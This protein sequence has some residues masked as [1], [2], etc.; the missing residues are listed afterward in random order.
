[1]RFSVCDFGHTLFYFQK[2]LQEK[3]VYDIVIVLHNL[4][5]KVSSR[6]NTLVKGVFSIYSCRDGRDCVATMR[7]YTFSVRSSWDALFYGG[8]KRR[9]PST[10]RNKKTERLEEPKMYH[11]IMDHFMRRI[12]NRLKFSD[13]FDYIIDECFGN[14]ITDMQEYLE[15]EYLEY[16]ALVKKR[17]ELEKIV[18][19]EE[20]EKH[21]QYRK[22]DAEMH[23]LLNKTLF[24]MGIKAGIKLAK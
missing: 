19:Q 3:K 17:A 9:R 2:C 14:I 18:F 13:E 12:G 10:E 8:V 22:V 23:S 24:L 15:Q 11:D 20:S 7:D 1:M 4:N 16:N 5:K 6:E 21:E